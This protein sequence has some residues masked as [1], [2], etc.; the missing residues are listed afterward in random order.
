LTVSFAVRYP[1]EQFASVG[2]AASSR[3]GGGATPVH[4]NRTADPGTRLGDNADLARLSGAIELPPTS[5]GRLF[6]L[7]LFG[8]DCIETPGGPIVLEVNEFPN[9]TGVPGADGRLAD[10][11]ES[12]ARRNLSGGAR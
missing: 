3:A 6:H 5:C 2:G 11:V 9:Y 8:V 1:L 12:W 4:G 10:F 7:D